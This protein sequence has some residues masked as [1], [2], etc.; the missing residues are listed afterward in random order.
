MV[1]VVITLL[2]P[3]R[4]TREGAPI[5]F[6]TRKAM[7][8]LAHLALSERP[9][10]REALC[11][12]LWP[13]RDLDRARGALRRT[14]STLRGAI[15]KEW[16]DTAG[17]SIALGQGAGL[18][19]DVA[20]FRALAGGTPRWRVSAR[21]LALASGELLEGFFLRD[22]ANFEHWQAG[23]AEGLRRELGSVLRRLVAALVARGDY[24]R[25]IE[26][27]QRWLEIDP[28]HEPAHRELI[29]L[30]G[31]TGNRADALEQ[32][33]RCV[34]TLSEELGVGPLEETVALYEQVEQEACPPRLRR[35]MPRPCDR[36][37]P[38]S[39]PRAAA[40]RAG[41]G[42]GGAR[43]SPRVR[44]PGWGAGGD[45]GRGRNREDTAGE[46]ARGTGAGGGRGAASRPAAT[47]TRRASPTDR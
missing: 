4:V 21:R 19:L 39:A 3:P 11:E 34:R 9:R 22:S 8:L 38:R 47:K 12:L 13:D 43:L 35:R 6:D 23:E 24:D 46:R 17:D 16:I 7:A 15:G 29:R 30:Y 44:R 10:S 5:S 1:A 40:R 32:Y 26:H 18:E 37:E 28:V 31:W 25:A 2:G 41:R 14:L 33:R 36:A 42:A 27:A 20:R 45:R